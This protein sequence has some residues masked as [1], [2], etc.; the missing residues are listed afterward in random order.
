M[1]MDLLL[2]YDNQTHTRAWQLTL[3]S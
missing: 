3:T 1:G 2:Q